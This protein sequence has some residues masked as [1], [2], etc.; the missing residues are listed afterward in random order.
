MLRLTFLYKIAAGSIPAIQ[1]EEYLTP[2]RKKR[3]VR[4]KKF[5]QYDAQNI[6]QNQATNNTRCSQVNITPTDN[7]NYR[8]SFFVKTITEWN[9]LNED[10]VQSLTTEEFTSRLIKAPKN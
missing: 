10:I 1:P 9:N 8:N 5:E 2:K 4:P 3:P 7:T 6:I